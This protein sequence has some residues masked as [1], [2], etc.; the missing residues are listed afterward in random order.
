MPFT[1][2]A[3][4]K[5][6]TPIKVM[7]YN[8]FY[9]KYLG[10]PSAIDF[11]AWNYIAGKNRKDR[12]INMI[13][14][15]TKAFGSSGPDILGVQ[16][17]LQN[18]AD[19]MQKAMVGYGLSGVCGKT[20]CEACRIFYRSNR[21]SKINSGTFWLSET[22]D[23]AGSVYPGA[24]YPR[25]A[26]WV[27]LKDL[28]N[29]KN[30]FVL[31][32]HWDNASKEA[33]YYFAQLIR[34][35][36]KELACN[37]AVLIMGDLNTREYEKPYLRLIGNE[38]ANGMR[39]KDTYRSVYEK[40]GNDEATFNGMKGETSGNRIDF[41]FSNDK[42]YADKATIERGKVFDKYPSDH[43]PVTATIYFVNET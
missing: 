16:E 11:N 6:G 10:A 9:D 26:S 18:Q 36:I 21:F 40:I 29:Q 13:M 3:E 20:G 33:N 38:D 24:A 2:L 39:L 37:I 1:V 7:S 22:P 42:C 17:T 19:D 8:I 35:K 25:I 32:T 43:Y 27:I 30:I 31:S 14:S 28:E 4:V 41:I 15:G 23:A 5:A 12:V 34:N